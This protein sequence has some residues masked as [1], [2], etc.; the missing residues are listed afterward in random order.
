MIR[1]LDR[2]ASGSVAARNRSA[3]LKGG[4]ACPTSFKAVGRLVV[5][6]VVS[7]A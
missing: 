2:Q 4:G 5:S 3:Q 1:A 6:I 7:F